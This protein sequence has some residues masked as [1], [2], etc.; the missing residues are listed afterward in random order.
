M[1]DIKQ[2]VDTSSTDFKQG[3]GCGSSS[4]DDTE[5][6]SFPLFK[7]DRSESKEPNLQD[8]KDETEE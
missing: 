2:H 1:T 3:V 6:R 8:E 4:A 7:S 5:E